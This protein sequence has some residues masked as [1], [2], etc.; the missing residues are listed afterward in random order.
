MVPVPEGQIIVR[1]PYCDLRS[2]VRGDR[3]LQRYQVQQRITREQATQALRRFLGSNIAIAR[4]AA[5]Q[6][7]LEE[8]FVAHLPFWAEWGRVLSW[9]FGEK[10]VGSGDNKRYEPREVSNIQEMSWTWCGM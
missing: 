10:R 6:A 1:C 3:G 8:V 4:D 7:R 9:V 5:A 2:M